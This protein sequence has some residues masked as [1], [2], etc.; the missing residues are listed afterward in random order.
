MLG[1]RRLVQA[2]RPLVEQALPVAAQRLLGKSGDLV[3]Q[4]LRLLQRM[5]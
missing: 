1:C 5:P 2:E 4:A 3:R